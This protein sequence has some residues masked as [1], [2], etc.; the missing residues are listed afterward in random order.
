[1]N[2]SEYIE[3]KKD[4]L[5]NEPDAFIKAANKAQ[6]RIY[7]EILTEL[8]RLDTNKDGSIKATA[9]NLKK[10]DVIANRI[11][12]IFK[13]SEYV[14]AVNEFAKTFNKI[15]ELNL[16]YF[17]KNFGEVTNRGIADNILE[18][19]KQ[20]MVEALVETSPQ[21]FISEIKP[22]LDNAVGTSQS[23]KDTVKQIKAFTEGNEDLDGR[24]VKYAKQIT[25]DAFST[26]DAMYTYEITSNLVLEFYRYVGGKIKDTRE[27]CS[28]RNGNY[29]HR[30]EVKEWGNLKDWNGRNPYTNEQTIFIL[31][32]GYNCRHALIPVSAA[33]VPKD[34]LIRA[35]NKGYFKPSAKEKELL[36]L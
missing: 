2:L 27:F 30:E 10:I 8:S 9:A 21:R 28:V 36:N 26:A 11:I 6:I 18:I 31:R 25:T 35:I 33:I 7:E 4:L 16:K 32:G 19:Q 23:W 34:V 17:E 5:D 3:R 24:I 15:K 20:R 14:E 12:K 13:D 22:I 29:Y 1:M